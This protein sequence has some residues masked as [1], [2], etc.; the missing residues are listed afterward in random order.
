MGFVSELKKAGS[1]IAGAASALGGFMA[2]AEVPNNVFPSNPIMSQYNLN[3]DNL[4]T[5]DV[6]AYEQPTFTIQNTG[7]GGI[8]GGYKL[9]VAKKEKVIFA[10][11]LLYSDTTFAISH[12]HSWGESMLTTALKNVGGLSQVAKKLAA[13]E[14]ALRVKPGESVASDGVTTEFNAFNSVDVADVYQ[15]S[16]KQSFDV[17]FYAVAYD[18]PINEVILPSLLFT[19]LSYP[20]QSDKIPDWIY[21]LENIKTSLTSPD[22]GKGKADSVIADSVKKI[23]NTLATKE[24]QEATASAFRTRVG[25]VPPS[26]RVSTSNGLLTMENAHIKDVTTTY[27][28]PWLANPTGDQQSVLSKIV[29]GVGALAGGGLPLAEV[30]PGA[31]GIVG[32]IENFF[33]K[34][35]SSG[36]VKVKG[37]P[38]YCEIKLSFES[39]FSQMFAEE[40]INPYADKLAGGKTE[41]NTVG[42][43]PGGS[44]RRPSPLDGFVPGKTRFP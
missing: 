17:T 20:R 12:S 19:Y 9:D 24:A 38:S 32:G 26:W 21:S 43:P 6:E 4:F 34:S 42:K 8:L 40:W 28:G 14:S 13:V 33:S 25:K 27:Y 3:E 22:K 44:T 41:V 18:D 16:G 11:Q 36:E 31:G 37:L 29:T 2:G 39:N 35:V 23:N 5:V 10:A 1:K 7:E 30:F 15:G